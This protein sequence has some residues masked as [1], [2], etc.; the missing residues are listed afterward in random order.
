[1]KELKIN[2]GSHLKNLRLESGKTLHELAM[3]VDIDSPML[4]KIERGHRLPTKDQI[5]KISA[6]FK[7]SETALTTMLTAEKILKEFGVNQVTYE[8]V[9]NV[10]KELAVLLKL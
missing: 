7:T 6:Y 9:K 4:S 2:L 8:A 3:K 5:K 1:M 10:E